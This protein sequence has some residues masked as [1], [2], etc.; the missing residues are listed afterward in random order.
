[1]VRQPHYAESV[2]LTHIQKV[3]VPEAQF[4]FEIRLFRVCVIIISF[5]SR[6]RTQ[7]CL[8]LRIEVRIIAVPRTFTCRRCSPPRGDGSTATGDPSWNFT[9]HTACLTVEPSVESFAIGFQSRRGRTA[10][11]R[12]TRPVR[13]LVGDCCQSGKSCSSRVG[14]CVV[15]LIWVK[16]AVPFSRARQVIRDPIRIV[17]TVLLQVRSDLLKEGND[18]A[19]EN[20][21]IRRRYRFI[22]IQALEQLVHHHLAA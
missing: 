17:S 1:M 16:A 20:C 11:R 3:V 12:N 21:S 18:L 5:V 4:R 22:Q 9:C 8:I 2:D 10:T 14:R 6:V 19:S 13:S 7:A 15:F